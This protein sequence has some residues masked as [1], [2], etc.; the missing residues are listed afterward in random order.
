MTDYSAELA[1]I[2]ASAREFQK[3]AKSAEWNVST[4][5]ADWIYRI[6]GC[7]ER[8]DHREAY[9]AL[10]YLRWRLSILPPEIRR[11]GL[12]LYRTRKLSR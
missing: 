7:R 3:Q 5:I 9:K 1:A 4:L 12:D 8:K 10:A 6:N 11:A 2:E